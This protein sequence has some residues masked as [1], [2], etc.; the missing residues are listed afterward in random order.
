VQS[1]PGTGTTVRAV[2]PAQEPAAEEPHT[3]TSS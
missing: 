2:F 3:I 1:A